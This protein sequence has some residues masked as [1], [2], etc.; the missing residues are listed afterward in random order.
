MVFLHHIVYG[1]NRIRISNRFSS[2]ILIWIRGEKKIRDLYLY[3]KWM[4]LS[5]LRAKPNRHW[6]VPKLQHHIW[7]CVHVSADELD[8]IVQ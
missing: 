7:L 8:A 1:I 6:K 4:P 3:A 5:P 2:Y